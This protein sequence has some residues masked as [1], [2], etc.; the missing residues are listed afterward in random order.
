MLGIGAIPATVQLVGVLWWIPESPRWLM[1]DYY[2]KAEKVEAQQIEARNYARDVLKSVRVGC[3]EVEI[4]NEISEIE[5]SLVEQTG[6][7]W[8]LLL[9]PPVRPALI[10]GLSLM[11]FQQFCGINTAMYY[12]PKIVQ[13][14]GYTNNSTAIWFAN[15]VA[16]SNAVFTVVSLFLIDRVG[17]RK[18]LLISITGITVAVAL[19]GV[20]FVF[21]GS[22]AGLLAVITLAVYVAFFALGL[23]PVPWAVNAEIYPASVRGLANGLAATVNWTAN[24]IVSMT[25]LSYAELIGTAGVFWT[26]AGAGVVAWFVVYTKLPETKGLSIDSVQRLFCAANTSQEALPSPIVSGTADSDQALDNS[27]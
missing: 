21:E 6:T 12:S 25:F 27:S 20:C 13:M 17:R 3:T 9:V 15:I 19:L 14:A 22:L 26:Y 5:N 8:K 18:L 24:L 23:G 7:T 2:R 4:D 10:I 16:F 11:V 1:V